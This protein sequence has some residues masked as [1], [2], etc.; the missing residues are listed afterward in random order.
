VIEQGVEMGRPSELHVS[1]DH[2][3][4]EAAAV[5]V[6]GHAVVVGEGSLVVPTA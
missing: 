6:G 1:L 3:G 2:D 5:L 4:S